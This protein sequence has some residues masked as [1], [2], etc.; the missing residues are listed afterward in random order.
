MDGGGKTRKSFWRRR[1]LALTILAVLA[2]LVFCNLRVTAD[3][4]GYSGFFVVNHGD[5]RTHVG[6]H[7][8][9]SVALTDLFPS[10]F[11][12]AWPAL[13]G[14]PRFEGDDDA[15][16]V[17]HGI[18][19][20][21]WLFAGVVIAWV[22]LIEVAAVG[23]ACEDG[24]NWNT[25]MP[26]NDT[27]T[28][29]FW[30]RRWPSLIVLVVAL[31]LAFV[32][33]MVIWRTSGA[34]VGLSSADGFVGFRS[35]ELEAPYLPPTGF[36]AEFGFGPFHLGFWPFQMRSPGEGSVVFVPVWMF[37]AAVLLWVALREWRWRVRQEPSDRREA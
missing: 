37:V 3:W 9:F 17:T 25:A 12:V 22:V 32:E 10:Y 19:I 28:K 16:G 26:M 13:G 29:S 18:S 23:T 35:W 34:V 1:W 14:A 4:K 24:R 21:I 36:T 5:L 33:F 2:L 27:K 8:D 7:T 30:R 15:Y 31:T 20:P 11:K 6:R